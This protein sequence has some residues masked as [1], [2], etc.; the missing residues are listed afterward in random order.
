MLNERVKRFVRESIYET[1]IIELKRLIQMYGS[2]VMDRSC[3]V[4]NK[5]RLYKGLVIARIYPTYTSYY[6]RN[7]YFNEENYSFNNGFYCDYRLNK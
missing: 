3:K 6:T 2:D 7:K 1:N 5:I 4:L